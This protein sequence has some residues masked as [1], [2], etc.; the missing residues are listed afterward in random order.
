MEMEYELGS[1]ARTD[2]VRPVFIHQ[3]YRQLELYKI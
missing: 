3:F 1:K 2:F